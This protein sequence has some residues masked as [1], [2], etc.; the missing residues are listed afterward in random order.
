HPQ[1]Q[2]VLLQYLESRETPESNEKPVQVFVT[3]HSPNFAAIAKIDTIGC[4]CEQGNNIRSFF[5]RTVDFEKRKKEKLQRYM[6]VTRAELYFAHRILLVEGA[7]ERFMV[8]AL[9]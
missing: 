2:A 5:P 1:M 7:A 3:S 9:A 6:D 8:E 4:L